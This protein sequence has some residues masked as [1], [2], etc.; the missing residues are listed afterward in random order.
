MSLWSYL[1]RFPWSSKPHEVDTGKSHSTT[2]FLAGLFTGSFLSP[3]LVLFF[4]CLIVVVSRP[5][6]QSYVEKQ[7][8]R[9][10]A[11]QQVKS[12]Y[13]RILP[14]SKTEPTPNQ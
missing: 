7:V 11:L 10:L 9:L 14:A 1:P 8:S 13:E 2:V 5:E 4:L 6:A 3:F 12:L